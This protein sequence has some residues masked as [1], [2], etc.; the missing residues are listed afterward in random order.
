MWNIWHTWARSKYSISPLSSKNHLKKG[1][2]RIISFLNVI[3]KEHSRPLFISCYSFCAILK[4]WSLVLGK[5]SCIK[6]ILEYA[7]DVNIAH[8]DFLV[9]AQ[10]NCL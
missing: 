4:K 10:T 7:S 5:G 9:C 3:K 1:T 8:Y 6:K 2:L